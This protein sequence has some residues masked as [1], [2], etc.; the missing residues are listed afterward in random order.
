M[1]VVEGTP[2]DFPPMRSVADVKDW[3]A[4][5]PIDSDVAAAYRRAAFD[6]RNAAGSPSRCVR[7]TRISDRLFLECRKR[8]IPTR[9]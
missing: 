6:S 1:N 7:L 3:L 4:S 5:G 2:A 8:G 9:G